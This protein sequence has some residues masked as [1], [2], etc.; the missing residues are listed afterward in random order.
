VM[1]EEELMAQLE[2]VLTNVLQ[3]RDHNRRAPRGRKQ[4]TTRQLDPRE[5]E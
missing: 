2:H 3:P 4:L 1:S 5:L